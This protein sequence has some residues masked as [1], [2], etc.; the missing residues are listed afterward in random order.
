M[1]GRG[2]GSGLPAAVYLPRIGLFLRCDRFFNKKF[3]I[4]NKY[5]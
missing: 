1:C 2:C 3:F 5:G 4:I